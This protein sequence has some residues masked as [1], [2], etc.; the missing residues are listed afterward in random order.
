MQLQNPI[1]RGFYP[2]PSI[3]EAEG[4]YYIACSSFQYLPGVPI[5]ESEDLVN[6]KQVANALTRTTQVELHQ[7]PSSGGVF[8]PTLR[9]H[10]GTFYM[11]TNNN[12]FG[13]N[14][15]ITT[16][17]IR[18]EWSD[19]I[20]VDQEG[21]DPSLLFD[22][23]KVYFTSNGSYGP[24]RGCILQCEIDIR[25]GKKLTESIPIWNGSGGRYIESPHLY[26]IGDWYY[27]MVAEGGTEYGHMITYA[28]S[29]DPFG[30]FEG[31]EGNPVLTNRNMEG[32][33]CRIQGIGHGD[34]I[35]DK[36]GNYYI[37]CLG[38]RQ[39]GEW[40]PYHHLGR[41]VFLTPVFWKEDGW[42]T[43]GEQGVVTEW[44]DVELDGKQDTDIYNVSSA[45]LDQCALRWS[46]LRD[47]HKENYEFTKNR[48]NLKGT[49]VTLEE[50]DTP[51]FM[52][53]RQSEFDTRLAVKVSGQ[54]RE[55]GVT[56]YMDEC[57]HY[58]LALVREDGARKVILRLHVGDASCVAGTVDPDQGDAAVE[59]L[60]T[61]DAEKYDFYCMVNGEKKFLGSART[62]YLSSEVAGGFTGV[63]M[64]LYA[65]DEAG[66]WAAFEDLVWQQG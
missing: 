54:A 61:S 1:I 28:R 51:T 65:V 34:L 9:Y 36:A 15:Y 25:T 44:M 40:Q 39:S 26:H 48:I 11:V 45:N 18:G 16:T 55:A 35:Q 17:D 58:D 41:E 24:D 64:G 56:F 5:F 19:P 20:F 30:P 23:G 8:A 62:K 13:K 3:C 60:V 7:V 32:H 46:Y 49:A 12:T 14:F 29:R 47:Y 21:I 57:Q 42:F 52:G 22:G 33:R 38:F 10:D 37:V 53:I 27:L 6:W 50:A 2:D 43:A 63:L 4:K 59:V 31:Y 66:K